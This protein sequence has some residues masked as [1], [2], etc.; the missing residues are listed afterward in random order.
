MINVVFEG[1]NETDKK[2]LIKKIKKIYN[3]KNYKVGMYGEIDRKSK[4]YK[5]FEKNVDDYFSSFLNKASNDAVQNV[6]S[7]YY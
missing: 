4:T 5:N 7:T 3:S 6:F 1:S 2:E